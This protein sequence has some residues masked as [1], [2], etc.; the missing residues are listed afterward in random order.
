M[1][2][3]NDFSRRGIFEVEI[4]DAGYIEAVLT[5]AQLD[6]QEIAAEFGVANADKYLHMLLQK[7]V[8]G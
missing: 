6:V 7:R 3:D 8:N 5:Q 1:V 4:N 2:S